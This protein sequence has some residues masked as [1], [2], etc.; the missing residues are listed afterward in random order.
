MMAWK[1]GLRERI[2]TSIWSTSTIAFLINMPIR[3]RKPRIAMNSN[4]AWNSSSPI[5]TPT[6]ASGTVSQIT[7]VCRIAL[8]ITIT[9]STI[10]TSP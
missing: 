5:A 6:T 9:A 8:N 3:L 2:S 10:A 1:R 4:G 7:A